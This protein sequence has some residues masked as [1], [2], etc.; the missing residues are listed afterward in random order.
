ML[1]PSQLD[2]AKVILYIENIPTN[3]LGY[4]QY[5]DHNDT[6]TALAI[7][8]YDGETSYYIFGCDADWNVISDTLHPSLNDALECAKNSYSLDGQQ[9]IK[10]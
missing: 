9:W 7:A 5:P 2:G 8:Q 10:A 6:V 1:A 4:V 3:D